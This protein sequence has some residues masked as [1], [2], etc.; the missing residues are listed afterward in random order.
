MKVY[1]IKPPRGSSYI[2]TPDR[3]C[4][5]RCGLINIQNTNDNECFKWCCKYHQT[6]KDKNDHRLTVLAKV[7]DRFN[8]EGVSYPASYEDI[9]T[10]E[11][12]NKIAIFVYALNDEGDPVKEK[13]GNKQF[14]DDVMYLLRVDNET[15]SHYI[16]IKHI[17]R[18][19]NMSSTGR[20]EAMTDKKFCPYC[21][22]LYELKKFDN[23][24]KYCYTD[25]FENLVASLPDE[26]SVM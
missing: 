11:V 12:N 25:D 2:P 7:N 3:Y 14:R 21:S 9:K 17:A 13:D 4:N 6:K 24:V 19:L 26:G 18:F 23:H 22:K 1:K 15:H 20:K 10:F 5:A 16:Y 8:Y